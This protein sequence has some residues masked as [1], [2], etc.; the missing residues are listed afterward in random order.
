MSV[1]MEQLAHLEWVNY[2]ASRSIIE[3]T[4]GLDLC[5]RDDVVLTSSSVFP[6][7]DTT[8]ACCLWADEQTVEKLL[9]EVIDYFQ[10]RNLPP[11]IYL[12]PAC[13]PYDLPARLKRRGF[14][15]QIGQEAWLVLEN[16][17][18]FT[19]P[20]A[21]PGFRVEPVTAATVSTFTRLFLSAFELPVELTPQ[22]AG[23]LEPSVGLPG[24]YHYL[25]WADEEPIGTSSLISY[26]DYGILGSVSVLSPHR[27]NGA[28]TNLV[29]E[30]LWQARADGVNTILLQTTANTFLEQILCLAG[31]RRAFIRTAYILS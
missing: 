22:L 23:L 15:P 31:F 11:T 2:A 1:N 26:Q 13:T 30:A 20:P 19:I 25:G 8:H 4:P 10:S 14:K 29:V 6:A 21:L 3:Q 27:R 9:D 7:P 28:G 24:V 18:D 5:I 16:L 17:A 12:S